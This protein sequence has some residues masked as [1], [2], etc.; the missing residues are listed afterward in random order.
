MSEVTT[1]YSDVLR[2]AWKRY[3]ELNANGITLT[4]KHKANRQ[5]AAL[6]GVVATILAVI[7]NQYTEDLPEVVGQILKYTLIGVPILIS[8]LAAY[9]NRFYGGGE[10]L[11][12]RAA[13]EE[14][15]KEIYIYRTI[16][17]GQPGRDK[18]MSHRLTTILRRV[19]KSM[20]GQL[21]LDPYEGEL[22]PYYYSSDPNS[23]PGF[24][25]LTGDE[26]L[27]YRLVDQRDW[28]RK[29]ITGLQAE[30]KRTQLIILAMGGIGALF[31]AIGGVWVAWV[32]V[33]AAIA[34]AMSGWEQ[35]RG[36]DETISIYSRVI[37]E[38]TI[39]RDDWES[40]A[41]ENRT[42]IELVRMVRASE[43]VMWSQSQKYVA[44]MQEALAAA[45]GDDAKLVEDMIS[46]GNET[47]AVIQEKMITQSAE[48]LAQAQAQ[49]VATVEAAGATV[50]GMVDSV[51]DEAQAYTALAEET[52]A[53]VIDE[54]AAVRA[55]VET[56][57]EAVMA[58]VSAVRETV[59]TVVVDESAA[60]Q[61]LVAA[62]LAAGQEEMAAVGEVV[63]ETVET[64]A[65]DVGAM[66]ETVGAAVAGES[67]AI[68]EIVQATLDTAQEEMAAV[69]ETVV[70]TVETVAA[71][72]GAVRET[73]GAAVADE[74]A[75]VQA[76]VAAT[77]ATAGDEMAAL[78][79]TAAVS[80]ATVVDESTALR[81]AVETTVDQ[82]A[83]EMGA[84]RETVS[85]SAAGLIDQ[86]GELRE[87]VAE[88]AEIAQTE[89]AALQETA[90]AAVEAVADDVSATRATVD[91][92]VKT[93][94]AEMADLRDT[95]ET[96]VDEAAGLRA[97]VAATGEMALD[98]M[99]ALR[100]RAETM[101]ATVVD[102]SEAVLG[103]VENSAD[104]VA[105]EMRDLG[106]AIDAEGAGI[107]SPGV[108]SM[109]DD[110]LEQISQ[111]EDKPENVIQN[112]FEETFAGE[113]GLEEDV[114]K[115]IEDIFQAGATGNMI[116]DALAGLLEEPLPDEDLDTKG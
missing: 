30:R 14:I 31:A 99:D 78:R 2:S 21:V 36:L 59:E 81:G 71:D 16:L 54:S 87:T 75:A 5:W 62:T 107:A 116:Q 3:A 19:Y 48:V 7:I 6:L 115:A 83:Q 46:K 76:L 74:S 51:T 11:T 42:F 33:S 98:E 112:L 56:A 1:G 26:Y 27:R 8:G 47:L 15:L 35:L 50:K 4:K 12:L 84:I 38:L 55:S 17:Q 68:Q 60:V 108:Q 85:E 29:K 97:T 61:A 111:A 103:A 67:A 105:Q 65:A 44:T 20:G 93:V 89:M 41:P 80:V 77:L 114:Q 32:A 106:E 86:A 13:A 88:T 79:E 69:R 82:A 45:E 94:Q 96:G 40:T 22:P 104:Q 34:S 23:D 66:R 64:V 70:E 18:W 58:D 102:E 28:H 49:V 101:V 10:W 53:Q 95:A 52:V 100:G 92:A 25:D 39:I 9:R 113:N 43:G 109:L 72:V 110:F 57:T 73:V 24:N 90:E 63:T 91:A 37:L